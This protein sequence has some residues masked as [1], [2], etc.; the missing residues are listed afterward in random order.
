MTQHSHVIGRAMLITY[1]FPPAGGVS[2]QRMLKFARYLPLYGYLPTV[3]TLDPRYAAYGATDTALLNQLPPEVR[4]VRTRAWDPFSLYAR[5]QGLQKKDVVS[6]CFASEGTPGWKQEA[7]RWIRGNVFLP[8]ARIGWVPYATRA[9]HRLLRAEDFRVVMT[10]GPP[11]S[12]HL[13]GSALKKRTGIP[14]IADLRDPWSDYY[15]NRFFHQSGLAG[16]IN[17]R[18]ERRVLLRA[19]AVLSVSESIGRRLRAKA[20]VR[21]YET[22]YNGYDPND[23]PEVPQPAK[24]GGRFVIAHVGTYAEQRHSE[25]FVKAVS[26]LGTEVELRLVGHVHESVVAS[27]RQAGLG[28]SLVTIPHVPHRDAIAQM[29]RAD[30]LLLPVER[31]DLNTGIVSGKVFEYLSVGKPV[32]GIGSPGGDAASILRETGGGAMFDHED[33][34]GMHAFMLDHIQQVRDGRPATPADKQAL[35]K[36]DRRIVTRRL[37]RIMDE[38]SSQ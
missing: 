5:V 37:A 29:A 17:A 33:A 14:W 12:A 34:Q 27:F 7:A 30:M 36:Y 19:D 38:I 24:R 28:G 10:S 3:V 21:R 8:D 31:S 16:F 9:A 4:I 18:L 22:L 13:V 1:Y 23:I 25:A 32:L 15:Y 26:R 2:V 20:P 35:S 6:T 11:H